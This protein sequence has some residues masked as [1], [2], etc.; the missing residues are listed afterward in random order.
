MIKNQSE[1][2][3]HQIA[4]YEVPWFENTIT[5]QFFSKDKRLKGIASLAVRLIIFPII[6]IETVLQVVRKLLL[7]LKLL[8]PGGIILIINKNH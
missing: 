2:T 6:P 4:Y 8:S 3:S 5:K 7:R 1:N